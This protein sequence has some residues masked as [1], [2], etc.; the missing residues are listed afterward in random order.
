MTRVEP[1][2]RGAS[3]LA[4]TVAM[5]L[6]ALASSTSA[7]P[8]AQS[9]AQSSAWPQRPVRVILPFGA[10]T[11][12]DVAARLMGEK[13]SVRWGRPI[14]IENRPGADGLLA[15]NAFIAANDDHVLLYASTASF[16]AHP[17]TLDKMPYSLER[18]L[19]RSRAS[20]TPCSVP[21]CR[22]RSRSIRSRRS[23]RSPARSPASSTPPAPPACP[24]SRSAIS[25][26]SRSST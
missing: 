2:G 26:T 19:A 17:Y 7:Q 24:T 10:G 3:L 14:V 8:P 22:R 25:C 21:A 9:A 15:I 20:P 5:A 23:S 6:C 4:A 12:T 11:A 13:L 1:R 16:M 18:D